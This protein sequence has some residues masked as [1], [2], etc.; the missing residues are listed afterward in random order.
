MDD[1]YNEMKLVLE[2]VEKANYKSDSL[3]SLTQNYNALQKHFPNMFAEA[4]IPVNPARWPAY[5]AGSVL[6]SGGDLTSPVK[7]LQVSNEYLETAKSDSEWRYRF[8]FGN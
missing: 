3:D 1:F 7:N 2:D 6:E 5:I 8:V 4:L